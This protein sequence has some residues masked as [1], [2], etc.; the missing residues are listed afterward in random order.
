M[1]LNT[2]WESLCSLAGSDGSSPINVTEAVRLSAVP[3]V[4]AQVELK[5]MMED[6]LLEG[7]GEV[8]H[9]TDRGRKSCSDVNLTSEDNSTIAPE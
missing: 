9:L 4:V 1:P 2:L 5:R 6:G 8:V 7:D 3:D